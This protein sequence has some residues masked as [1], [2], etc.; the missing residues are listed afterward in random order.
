MPL[1]HKTMDKEAGVGCGQAWSSIVY[2]NP[3]N[4]QKAITGYKEI[5]LRG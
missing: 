4:I 3:E 2:Q 5:N 1:M